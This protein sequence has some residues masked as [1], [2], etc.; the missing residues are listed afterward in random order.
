MRERLAGERLDDAVVAAAG[1]VGVALA[2]P[3]EDEDGGI[4]ERRGER[5]RCGV[6]QVVLDEAHALGR[7]AGEHRRDELRRP[8]G[9]QRAQALP[10]VGHDVGGARGE[11]GVV[12][13]RHSVELV[14]AQPGLLEAPLHRSGRQLPRRE[15]HRRLAVLAA[16]QALLLARGHDAAVDDE[17]RGRIVED[18][19]DAEHRAHDRPPTRRRAGPIRHG[20]VSASPG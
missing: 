7:H 14:V 17:G 4:A 12:G 15:R 18:G 13:V 10:S 6:G 8:L 19:I 2:P 1:E 3:V 16:G 9:V 5:R 20:V 11:H